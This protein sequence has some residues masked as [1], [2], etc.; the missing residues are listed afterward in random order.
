MG[1]IWRLIVVFFGSLPAVAIEAPALKN[2][3]AALN[4]TAETTSNSRTAAKDFAGASLSVAA[5]LA[6]NFGINVQ[7]SVH[8]RIAAEGL[9]PGTHLK[10][11]RWWVGIGG[12]I[13]GAVGDFI[14]L[15]LADQALCTALGGAATLIGNVFVAR[16]W[17]KEELTKYDLG[18]VALIASGAVLLASQSPEGQEYTLEEL[19]AFF[20][21]R[22]FVVYSWL[23]VALIVAMLAG[24]A[25]S[26][27]YRLRKIL[28]NVVNRP[29]VRRMDELVNLNS[30]LLLR[31]EEHDEQLRFLK[32]EIG[33]G[34]KVNVLGTYGKFQTVEQRSQVFKTNA[35]ELSK[36]F[37]EA[38]HD[39][40]RSTYMKWEDAFLY[41]S[42]SGVV[43][44]CSVT[45]VLCLNG[46]MLC[47]LHQT[48][49]GTYC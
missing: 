35:E 11:F 23:V 38:E 8:N 28:I 27:F 14:A 17:L 46:W 30:M 37:E 41:A 36:T 19:V 15:G 29:L 42:C 44:A 9:P 24:I 5:S 12:T 32:E 48:M 3:T 25:N 21:A 45:L 13:L 10:S 31:L 43:G 34:K 2:V 39:K 18:G 4:L 6:S 7:K 22:N 1:S 20:W 47:Q 26:G 16:F 33:G 40:E 49:H